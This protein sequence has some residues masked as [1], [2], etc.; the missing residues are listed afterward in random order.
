MGM[1][2]KQMELLENIADALTVIAYKFAN[3]EETIR[4]E[5]REQIGEILEES[6]DEIQNVIENKVEEIMQAKDEET[7]D[8]VDEDQSLWDQENMEIAD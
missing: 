8:V 2:E 7:V 5:M 4:E 3:Q 6:G 1:K